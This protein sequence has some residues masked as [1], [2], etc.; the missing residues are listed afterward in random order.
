MLIWVFWHLAQNDLSSSL[1]VLLCML[2]TSAQGRL[3]MLLQKRTFPVFSCML[4]PSDGLVEF[5]CF[6]LNLQLSKSWNTIAVEINSIIGS[7]ISDYFS[8][9]RLLNFD[10][11][12][13]QKNPQPLGLWFCM[14][15]LSQTWWVLKGLT[16]PKEELLML[17]TGLEVSSAACVIC[18]SGREEVPRGL[19]SQ[20]SCPVLIWWRDAKRLMMLTE[21]KAKW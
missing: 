10:M 18:A 2:L 21:R 17:N 6:G 19:N 15:Y 12:C 20:Q 8:P 13:K 11:V 5:C 9:L 4:Y 14:C 1:K 3:W 7:E 16:Q